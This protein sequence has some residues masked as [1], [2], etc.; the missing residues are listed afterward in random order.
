MSP[1]D[2]RTPVPRHAG[3]LDTTPIFAPVG[4]LRPDRRRLTVRTIERIVDRALSRADLKRPGRSA[5]SLRHTYA[6]LCV[7]T[8]GDREALKEA[9]G[10]ANIETTQIYIG[11]AS[12]FQNNP[13]AGIEAALQQENDHEQA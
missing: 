2:E 4:A 6:I 8:G 12:R 13:A 9:M 11:V 3:D 5:H 10:H 1:L 7:L